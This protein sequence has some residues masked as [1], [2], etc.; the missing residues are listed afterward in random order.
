[1]KTKAP[2]SIKRLAAARPMP[3]APPVITA[4]FPFSLFMSC[5]LRFAVSYLWLYGKVP[6]EPQDGF[7][8]VGR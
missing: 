5:I 4:V 7:A 6:R 2:S 8:E 1:M 3:V